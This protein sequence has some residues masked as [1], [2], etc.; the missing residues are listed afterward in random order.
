MFMY[1]NGDSFILDHELRLHWQKIMN[2]LIDERISPL[3]QSK[4][5]TALKV[6]DTSSLKAFF[7]HP[8]AILSVNRAHL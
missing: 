5:I 4:V 6:F 1:L 7:G 3:E 2:E 8:I